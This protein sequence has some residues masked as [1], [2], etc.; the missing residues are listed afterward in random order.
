MS[1]AARGACVACLESIATWSAARAPPVSSISRSNP[2]DQL[3]SKA[4]HRSHDQLICG[5]SPVGITHFTQQ[6]AKSKGCSTCL[7]RMTRVDGDQKS[8]ARAGRI[9]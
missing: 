1:L 3:Q 7:E 5:T 9:G 8:A 2:P 6:L 4:S